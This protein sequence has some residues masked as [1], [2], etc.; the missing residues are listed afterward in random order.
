MELYDGVPTVY[1]YDDY[2]FNLQHLKARTNT[3]TAYIFDLQYTDDVNPAS[4]HLTLQI[5]FICNNNPTDKTPSPLGD[6]NLK[7]TTASNTS[8]AFFQFAV[9]YN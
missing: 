2:L 8:A 7:I 3:Q 5:S 1:R 6:N 9:T 4:S